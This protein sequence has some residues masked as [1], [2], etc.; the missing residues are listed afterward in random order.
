MGLGKDVSGLP[1]ITNLAQIPHLLIAGSTGSGKS[2]GIN[3]MI[4]SILFKAKPDEVKF[5]MIDPKVLELSV[6]DGIPHLI[7]PV[8]TNP[9][10]AATALKWAVEEME[11]R[12]QLMTDKGVKNID[13][14]NRIVE[15]EKKAQK[16]NK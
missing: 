11:K 4:C 1:V 8:V 6:Y 13:G 5:I 2:V 10:K 12:Y 14:Y 9:K 7:A 16:N 15:E 3:G